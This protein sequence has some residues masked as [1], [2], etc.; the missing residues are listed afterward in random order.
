MLVHVSAFSTNQ[1]HLKLEAIELERIEILI[2][3]A[4]TTFFFVFVYLIS[5]VMS[6]SA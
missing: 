3:M 6:V 4:M 2:Y 1:D 5:E